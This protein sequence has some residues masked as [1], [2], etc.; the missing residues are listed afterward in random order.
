MTKR[1]S[2]PKRA[3]VRELLGTLSELFEVLPRG[4]KPFYIWYA[5]ISGT[6]GLVETVALGLM[7][8]VITPLVT[9]TQMTLPIFGPIPESWTLGLVLV[10]CLLFI[11]KGVVA[12]MMHWFATRRFA[13]YELEVG[14]DLFRA[15]TRS[16]WEQ[17]SQLSTAEVTRIVDSSMANTNLGFILPLSQVPGNVVTFVS[18]LL[19]LVV[20][21][22]WIALIALVYL[23]IV[24][25]L[26]MVV[27]NRRMRLAGLHNRQFAYRVAT[28]MTEMVDALKEVTLRGK[29]DEVGEV[30]QQNRRRATR[31][32]AN[33]SFLG[34]VPKYAME[35]A[36]IG[37]FLLVGGVAYATG[38]LNQALF[39]V[40]LFGVTG[41]RMIPALNS[42]QATL[43]QASANQVYAKDVI[44][45][46]KKVEVDEVERLAK[47]TEVLPENPRQLELAGVGFRYP[48]A[49]KDV[50]DDISLTVPFGSTLAIVGPSGAGKSTLVDVILGL[51][52]ASRGT[53]TIDG[54]PLKTVMGQWRARVGYVPQRVALFD[55][56]I[57]QNVALTWSSEYDRD[58]VI[59]SLE[60]ADLHELAQR[61]DGIAEKV[62]ERGASISGGQQQ[63]LGIA[64]ALYS[65]PLIMVMDEATSALDTA[66][67][68][69]VTESLEK[70]QGDVTFITVAHRLATI[71][72]YD[73]ICYLDQGRILGSGTFMEVVTQVPEFA[74][75]AALAG[76]LDEN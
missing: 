26:I 7:L 27:L 4:A 16:T 40:A 72:D 55:A 58:R 5:I 10:M 23:G 62:G 31:A 41:F 14:N 59:S 74:Q 49:D 1:N 51:S 8:L 71:R 66:T 39:A 57:A 50:L 17:R 47:D 35:S 38:G 63:R 68:R 2:A 36:L 45:E 22:P 60:R 76:L 48:K 6:L 61:G 3:G 13:R 42:I 11:L 18:I 9:G 21:E 24:A 64:R 54:L 67:E 12:V 65:D 15:Y 37:G 25:L 69:R 52:E 44:R 43:A 28:I 34:V 19:V 73:Q 56:S 32:R 33:I 53:M 46:L 20:A 75:Q 70:L 30:L 29:L